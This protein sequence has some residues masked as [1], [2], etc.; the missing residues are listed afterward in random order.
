MSPKN[1]YTRH[2]KGRQKRG[3]PKKEWGDN[4]KEWTGHSLAQVTRLADDRKEWRRLISISP[5]IGYGV[6]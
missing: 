5:A 6:R 3:Q 2:G 4:I 1:N